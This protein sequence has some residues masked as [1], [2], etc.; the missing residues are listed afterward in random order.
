MAPTPTND[1]IYT[2]HCGWLGL[3]CDVLPINSA[4]N[5]WDNPNFDQCAIAVVDVVATASVVAKGAK[6]A[7]KA[8]DLLG[9]AAEDAG[10][11][12]GNLVIGKVDDLEAPGALG[13]GDR[14]LLSRLKPSLGPPEANWARNAG[15]L[16]EEMGSG[17]PIRDA[18][19]NPVAGAL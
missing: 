14:T 3:L 13:P 10:P 4:I 19:V 12:S 1:V 7:G 15:I 18:S 11:A 5:C 9:K 6:L 8:L 17:V 16:R 2:N